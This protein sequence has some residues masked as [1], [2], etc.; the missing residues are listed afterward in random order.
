MACLGNEEMLRRGGP[1]KE[2]LSRMREARRA[3]FSE[4]EFLG[5]CSVLRRRE[6]DVCFSCRNSAEIEKTSMFLRSVQ[7]G[8]STS[9]YLQFDEQKAVDP[10][11]RRMDDACWCGLRD[12]GADGEKEK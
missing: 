12:Q 3:Q 1:R 8:K 5:L 9:F 10:Y 7:N 11:V 2:W 6:L 4:A